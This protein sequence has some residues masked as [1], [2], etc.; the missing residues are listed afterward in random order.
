MCALSTEKEGERN[1]KEDKGNKEGCAPSS[2]SKTGSD[3][4]RE[5]EAGVCTAR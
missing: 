5:G 1:N 3:K 2:K 4:Q